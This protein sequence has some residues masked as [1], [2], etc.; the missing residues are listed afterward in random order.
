M[1]NLKHEIY[2]S[3]ATTTADDDGPADSDATDANAGPG[4]PTGPG[5]TGGTGTGR[6]VASF[7]SASVW[8]LKSVK[9]HKKLTYNKSYS[10]VKQVKEKQNTHKHN[11]THIKWYNL[12]NN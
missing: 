1:Q 12:K 11:N 2:A 9:N 4:R 3:W 6:L 8:K 10:P 5:C 7:Q